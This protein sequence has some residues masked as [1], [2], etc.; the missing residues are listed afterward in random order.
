M[1]GPGFEPGLL[2]PQRSVLTTRR[3]RLTTVPWLEGDGKIFLL[4]QTMHSGCYKESCKFSLKF[5]IKKL[6]LVMFLKIPIY[7]KKNIYI[8]TLTI[9]LHHG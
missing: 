9:F 5:A 2:R 3:S 1:P 4:M 7:S 6:L 8:P